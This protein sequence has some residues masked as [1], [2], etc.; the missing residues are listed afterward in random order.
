MMVEDRPGVMAD[1]TRILANHLIS[2]ASVIQHEAL[3]HADEETEIV[4]LIIMTHTVPT[5][6]FQAA[7]AEI[8]RLPSVRP[9]SVYF[10]VGD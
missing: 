3:D 9:A 1:I 2:I 8:D 4:P 10:P 6:A 5:G 7:L